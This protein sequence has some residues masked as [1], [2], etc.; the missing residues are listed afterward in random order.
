MFGKTQEQLIFEIHH[1]FDTASEKLLDLAT[2]AKQQIKEDSKAERLK[3]LGF[4]KLPRVLENDKNKNLLK[5]LNGNMELVE[6]YLQRYPFQKFIT[7]DQLNQICKKYHLIYAPVSRYLK[8]VP[9]KNLKEIETAPKLQKDDIVGYRH[10]ISYHS[11]LNNKTT[12][13]QKKKYRKG[14]TFDSMDSTVEYPSST[15]TNLTGLNCNQYNSSG[16]KIQTTCLKDLFIAAP[17]SHFDLKGFKKTSPFSF[18]FVT[19]VITKDP[20]VFRYVKGG[21]QVLSKWGLEAND[22]ELVNSVEN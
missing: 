15:F 2:K 1:E 22:E 17:K 13:S 8:D 10:H 20:I 18:N 9:E 14:I 12:R 19:T 3:K 11:D 6:N 4:T 7:E 21:I 5:D 16:W